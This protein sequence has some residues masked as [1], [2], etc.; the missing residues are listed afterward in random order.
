MSLKSFIAFTEFAV[1]LNSLCLELPLPCTSE[2]SIS[3]HFM[4]LFSTANSISLN[5]LDDIS[6]MSSS[7]LSV[8][9]WKRN[10]T[11]AERTEGL[12]YDIKKSCTWMINLAQ[13]GNIN[14]YWEVNQTAIIA[15]HEN[16]RYRRVFIAIYYSDIID[17]SRNLVILR[18]ILF[19]HVE[20]FEFGIGEQ[21]SNGKSNV[22]R[23]SYWNDR[24]RNWSK[25][26]RQWRR[27][28]Q[29]GYLNKHFW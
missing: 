19:R 22:F 9:K 5:R 15:L 17:I 24:M 21:M 14:I 6:F 7:R 8:R 26:R 13:F 1:L 10:D 2:L 12:T 3:D 4:T 28:Y 11:A 25:Q 16:N 20:W 29:V 23:W 27:N 18:T